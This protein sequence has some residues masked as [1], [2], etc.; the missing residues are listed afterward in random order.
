MESL[1]LEAKYAQGVHSLCGLSLLYWRQFA[2]AL[3]TFSLFPITLFSLSL[4]ESKFVL[5]R[6]RVGSYIGPSCSSSENKLSPPKFRSKLGQRHRAGNLPL[7]QSSII[8]LSDLGFG[9]GWENL[10]VQNLVSL[11]REASEERP[12]VLL[13]QWNA[14]DWYGIN[15][16]LQWLPAT[17]LFL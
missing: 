1:S 4:H 11:Y 2:L 3:R 8:L 9:N 6:Q 5:L 14:L 17:L 15:L 16:I 7:V 10:L 13:C 12:A